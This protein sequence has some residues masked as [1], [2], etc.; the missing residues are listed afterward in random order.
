MRWQPDIFR[1]DK[2]WSTITANKQEKAK[3]NSCHSAGLWQLLAV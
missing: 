1:H 2:L 3:R